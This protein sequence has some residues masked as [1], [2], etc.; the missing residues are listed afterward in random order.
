MKSMVN[1]KVLEQSIRLA[2][3]AS[4]LERQCEDDNVTQ[5]LHEVNIMA[6]GIPNIV[7][8]KSQDSQSQSDIE[9]L[10]NIIEGLKSKIKSLP[11]QSEAVFEF[12]RLLDLESELVLKYY[13]HSR[14]VKR[15]LRT[16]RLEI[17]DRLRVNR[18]FNTKVGFQT[19]LF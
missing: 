4:D 13:T 8:G 18:S 14:E 12:A 10:L 11:N 19:S 6:L 17:Q 1:F 9:N 2:S 16:S 7:S 15:P 3:K 5:L